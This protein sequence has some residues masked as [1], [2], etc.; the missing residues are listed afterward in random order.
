VLVLFRLL[1]TPDVAGFPEEFTVSP[2]IGIFIALIA[3]GGM[4]Y[5]GYRSTTEV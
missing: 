2:R 3:A 1:F 5:G 4:A